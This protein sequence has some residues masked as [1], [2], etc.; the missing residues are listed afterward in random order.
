MFFLRRQTD[1]ASLGRLYQNLGL[2]HRLFAE[3]GA[4]D[5]QEWESG[6]RL[7]SVVPQ[8]GYV[9]AVIKKGLGSRDSRT[10]RGKPHGFD[11]P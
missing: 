5:R 8:G 6:Q 11:N 3:T 4:S 7:S 9:D 2:H 10:N 1:T